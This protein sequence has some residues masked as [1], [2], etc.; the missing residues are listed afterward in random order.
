MSAA[1]A[2]TLALEPGTERLVVLGDPHGDILGLDEVFA[3]ED[4]PGTAYVSVGDN[5]G[6]A[7]GE[8][9][10][11]L[12]ALLQQRGIPSVLGNHEATLDDDGRM[13]L[14]APGLSATV[15]PAA[16][17]WARALPRRLRVDAPAR[18][19][20]RISVVHTLPDW[21]YVSARAAERLLDVEQ[22]DLVLCGHS[23]RAAVYRVAGD[24]V[25]A[26]GLDPR[27][28]TPLRVPW[29]DGARYVVDAGSLGRPNSP[30]G[31][32][33]LDRA[34]YAV[35]DFAAGELRLHAFDKGPR[36]RALFGFDA[37]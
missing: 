4:G 21:S 30:R 2:A 35:V 34:T 1:R 22:V 31:G 5:V 9:S 7:D 16:L 13:L 25:T 10:S 14:S 36:L 15:T 8:T 29:E 6:Y 26:H 18:P 20:A 3:R 17:A 24:G 32:A 28:K 12:V 27:R 11:H 23:H 19:A 33:R 37:T